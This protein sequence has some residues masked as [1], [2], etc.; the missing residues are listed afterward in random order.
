MSPEQGNL[1]N[2]SG[3][4]LEQAVK[5]VF[6]SKGFTIVNY[7]EWIKSPDLHGKE[8][9]LLNAPYTSIY[10]HQ[11]RTEFLAMSERYNFKIRIECKWQQS[12]GSVDEKLPY[13]YL[14]A[15]EAMPENHI[16]IIIDGDGFKEGAVSWLRNAVRNNLYTNGTKSD[17][18]IEILNL[19]EFLTWAN[20]AIK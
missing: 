3:N 13:L 15:I 11:G 4:A 12:S 9:L 14:N 6:Q 7:S 20:R 16:L 2:A 8:L 10:S 18:K 17:K 1:A 19:R 5:S